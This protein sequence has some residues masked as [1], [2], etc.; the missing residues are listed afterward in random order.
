MPQDRIVALTYL[1]QSG[2]KFFLWMPKSSYVGTELGLKLSAYVVR[3]LRDDMR[4]GTREFPAEA[5]KGHVHE[6][7]V[8]GGADDTLDVL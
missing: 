4:A 8:R 7:L 2:Q 6:A 5:V 3:R 1:F